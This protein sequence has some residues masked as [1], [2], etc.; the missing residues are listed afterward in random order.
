TEG[1]T[2][3]MAATQKPLHNSV[4]GASVPTAA[5]KSIHS[6]DLVSQNDHAINPDLK[7]LYAT[8]MG[9]KT[10]EVN[11]RR[12]DDISHPD[13]VAKAIAQAAAG[14]KEGF[15]RRRQTP[16]RAGEG[17]D[18]SSARDPD[19]RG[20]RLGALNGDGFPLRW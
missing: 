4:F 20:H 7:R 16:E 17:G 10:S 9:G 6:W 18:G 5:G 19:D 8:R 14:G 13:E 15:R 1:E 2:R 11:A 3:V 12:E